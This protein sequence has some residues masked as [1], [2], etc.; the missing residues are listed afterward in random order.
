MPKAEAAM[1]RGGW[2]AVVGFGCGKNMWEVLCVPFVRSEHHLSPL[3]EFVAFS[4]SATLD[5]NLAIKSLWSKVEV[6]ALLT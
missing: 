5:G 4:I 2:L 3:H 1:F 6:I